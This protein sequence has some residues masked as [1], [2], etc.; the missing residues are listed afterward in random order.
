LFSFKLVNLLAYFPPVLLACLL[1]VSVAAQ[2][3][4]QPG[5]ETEEATTT[6]D[7]SADDAAANDAN[8]IADAADDIEDIEDADLDE[9][10]YEEDDDIFIPTEEIPADEPI[11]FPS[12]I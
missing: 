1:S 7:V 12:N 2:Q 3:A 8:E 4:D 10:T 9:Q 11:P 6:E 5:A